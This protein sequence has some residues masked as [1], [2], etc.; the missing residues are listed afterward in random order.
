MN[1]TELGFAMMA[2]CCLIPFLAGLGLGWMIF[3]KPYRSRENW[4][5]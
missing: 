3:N 5:E 4:R 1:S 2:L